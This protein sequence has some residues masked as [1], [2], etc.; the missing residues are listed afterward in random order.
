M[1]ILITMYPINDSVL[2]CMSWGVAIFSVGILKGIIL[3]QAGCD[4]NMG[5]ENA[6]QPLE[7][8]QDP[9]NRSV[10]LTNRLRSYMQRSIG[11]RLEDKRMNGSEHGSS[12]LAVVRAKQY[13]KPALTPSLSTWLNSWALCSTHKYSMNVH[14]FREPKLKKYSTQL[15]SNRKFCSSWS[16]STYLN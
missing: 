9:K 1:V 8:W 16:L 12:R 15:V 3:I 2:N 5:P 11:C 7:C 10:A 13:Y 14:W 6:Q 4:T